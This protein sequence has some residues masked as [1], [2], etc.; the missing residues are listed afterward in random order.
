MKKKEYF[1]GKV[2]TFAAL[3]TAALLII[4][5]E[6]AIALDTSFWGEEAEKKASETITVNSFDSSLNDYSGIITDK[7]ALNETAKESA[8]DGVTTYRAHLMYCYGTLDDR[9]VQDMNHIKS[10][11]LK[12]D[13]YSEANITSYGSQY[14]GGNDG[15]YAEYSVVCNKI[16]D[17]FK[18]ADDDDVNLL[19][20]SGHGGMSGSLSGLCVT[21]SRWLKPAD[22]KN[23]VENN[24]LKGTFIIIADACHSGGYIQKSSVKS[25]TAGSNEILA[26]NSFDEQNFVDG[27]INGFY[28]PAKTVT[29]GSPLK[30]SAKYKVLAAA[31][32][33]QT[34]LMYN[35]DELASIFSTC[36]SSGLGYCAYYEN[37]YDSFGADANDDGKVELRELYAWTKNQNPTSLA[38]CYPENDD[39]VVASYNRSEHDGAIL[40]NVRV[41][42]QIIPAGKKTTV[43]ISYETTENTSVKCETAVMETYLFYGAKYAARSLLS[44]GRTLQK[45]IVTLPAGAYDSEKK[46]YCGSYI[47]ELNATNITSS[48][49]VYLHLFLDGYKGATVN[50]PVNVLKSEGEGVYFSNQDKLSMSL[51]DCIYEA[52]VSSNKFSVAEEPFNELQIKVQFG[53]E[54][55]G[56]S[57]PLLYQDKRFGKP[58]G[59]LL[60]CLIKDSSGNIVRTIANDLLVQCVYNDSGKTDVADAINDF[61]WNGKDDNDE[62][63]YSG[64]YTISLSA[65]YYTFD[66]SGNLIYT[67]KNVEDKTIEVEAMSNLYS[68]S[69]YADGVL[70]GSEPVMEGNYA[71]GPAFDT[72]KTGLVFLG[73]FTKDGLLSE[74]LGDWGQKWDLAATAV[75]ADTSL[76]ARWGHERA[77]NS[78]VSVALS[79]GKMIFEVACDIPCNLIVSQ[80]HEGK[81]KDNWIVSFGGDSSYTN[82]VSLG[83][84][85]TDI[86][87]GEFEVYIVD[88]SFRPV[89]NAS[90]SA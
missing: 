43:T 25:S 77:E 38:R 45:E 31:S 80:K 49:T 73:W 12:T 24:N 76:Y 59:V 21:S 8:A 3:A 71:A 20:Y 17:A 66:S 89:I 47:L 90:L 75:T 79:D 72:E 63:V 65:K 27:F 5:M 78:I 40:S 42:K 37:K 30:P 55:G 16:V 39:F 81:E 62:L 84:G 60:T 29:K 6:A 14:Y 87:A 53:G 54:D 88:Q 1:N 52:N 18:N 4:N 57:V 28:Q 82:I 15:E 85:I 67:T 33:T 70:V 69:F 64:V 34:S 83:E 36:V 68:V 22:L 35:S 56:S 9:T 11:L 46:R 51:S 26:D 10:S 44:D 32:T 41:D 86:P 48:Q 2:K 61:Y 19:Y 50:V 58:T 13:C 23:L 74:N 7:T